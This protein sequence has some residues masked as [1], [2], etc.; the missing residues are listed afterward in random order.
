ML[1]QIQVGTLML[2][3]Q[4]YVNYHSDS[5]RIITLQFYILTI[6]PTVLFA[7]VSVLVAITPTLTDSEPTDSG[8]D[9]G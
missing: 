1:H 3:S 6:P 9:I 4:S 5:Q 7:A 8:D 2:I